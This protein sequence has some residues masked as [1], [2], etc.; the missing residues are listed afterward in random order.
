MSQDEKEKQNKNNTNKKTVI[1]STIKK[2]N[3][4][5]FPKTAH[6]NVATQEYHIMQTDIPTS[7]LTLTENKN[8]KLSENVNINKNIQIQ[9]V[10]ETKQINSE[11]KPKINE[12]KNQKS[13][14]KVTCTKKIKTSSVIT[15]KQ[16]QKSDIK[17]INDKKPQECFCEQKQNYIQKS[18]QIPSKNLKQI[19]LINQNGE[20]YIEGFGQNI[21]EYVE[22]NQNRNIPENIIENN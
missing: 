6:S 21:N 16:N 2:I 4:N 10:I 12:N 17:Y 7:K 15:K 8:Q 1:K 20:E 13:K 9:R 11:N 19:K 18:N 22:T 14:K 5:T 3:Y